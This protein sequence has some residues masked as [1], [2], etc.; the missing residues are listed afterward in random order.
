MGKSKY[1]IKDTLKPSKFVERLTEADL[2]LFFQNL[3]MD[4]GEKHVC[5]N[6]TYNYLFKDEPL[7]C[8]TYVVPSQKGQPRPTVQN[9]NIRDKS[10]YYYV[11]CGDFAIGA[12]EKTANKYLDEYFLL[13][14]GGFNSNSWRG[15]LLAKFGKAYADAFESYQNAKRATLEKQLQGEKQAME[16]AGARYAG[17]FAETTPTKST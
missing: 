3:G 9:L 2:N 13:E 5:A 14:M 1:E 11:Y 7:I 4:F 16:N 10:A 6:D 17:K 15:F 8:R 12:L